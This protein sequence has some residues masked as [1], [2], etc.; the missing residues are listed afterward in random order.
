MCQGVLFSTDEIDDNLNGQELDL[1]S[2]GLRENTQH[3]N[4]PKNSRKAGK[5]SPGKFSSPKYKE[6]NE[7]SPSDVSTNGTNT[8]NLGTPYNNGSNHPYYFEDDLSPKHMVPAFLKQNSTPANIESRS[9]T[10][11]LKIPLKK[12]VKE[13]LAHFETSYI[14][15]STLLLK[16][17]E[18]IE[19]EPRVISAAITTFLRC[20]NRVTPIWNSELEKITHLKFSQL[21]SCFE[22]IYKKYSN[23][24]NR[25]TPKLQDILYTPKNTRD[26][27]SELKLMKANTVTGEKT[28][29]PQPKFESAS[30]L[31]LVSDGYSCR[32]IPI[33]SLVGQMDHRPFERKPI[34]GYQAKGSIP[35]AVAANT[36]S[37]YTFLRDDLKLRTSYGDGGINAELLQKNLGKNPIFPS[38][39]YQPGRYDPNQDYFGS[40][41]G[42]TTTRSAA[43]N[44]NAT[45]MS[46]LP[47]ACQY[48]LASENYLKP[49]PLPCKN[50]SASS[51]STKINPTFENLSYQSKIG[52]FKK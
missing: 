10:S 32:S 24:F 50:P 43:A 23:T 17:V 28:S 52:F 22:L 44:I 47:A 42:C 39:C 6:N 13:I 15:L 34:F 26:I 41:S 46:Y 20:V 5:R 27:K 12:K 8:D 31:N 16:D 36:S 19:W 49:D 33:S 3:I 21:S 45:S 29:Y 2:P 4:T 37:S 1:R 30:K 38:N 35:A 11:R 14:R 48:G 7:N 18:F 51:L 40:Y 25:F 9:L